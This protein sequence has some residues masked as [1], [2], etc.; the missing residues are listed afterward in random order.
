MNRQNSS[1]IMKKQHLKQ[2]IFI[3]GYQRLLDPNY[4]QTVL[5]LLLYSAVAEDQP[6][7]RLPFSECITM[8]CG[9]EDN[10]PEPIV[11]HTLKIF[12]DMHEVVDDGSG[13]RNTSCPK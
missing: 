7:D 12:S 11:F 5:Q 10:I 9:G 1:P 3:P 2:D 13:M 4:Q 6:F 8:L